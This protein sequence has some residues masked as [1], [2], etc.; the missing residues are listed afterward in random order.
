VVSIQL[1]S[2]LARKLMVHILAYLGVVFVL[3]AGAQMY[4]TFQLSKDNRDSSVRFTIK[5]LSPVL[6]TSLWSYEFTDVNNVADAFINNPFITG[7]TIRDENGQDVAQRGDVAGHM[8]V[9]TR[10]YE[11][12]EINLLKG[13]TTYAYDVW[14]EGRRKVK[15]GEV[16]LMADDSLLFS[17]IQPVFQVVIYSQ[18]LLLLACGLV[19]YLVQNTVVARPLKELA[20]GITGIK[21]GIQ[22]QLP[23]EDLARQDDELGELFRTFNE[24]KTSLADRDRQLLDHQHNLEQKVERR[25]Q[26][27]RLANEELESSLEKLKYAHRDLVESEKLASLGS[28]VTGVAHEVNTPLGVSITATSFLNTELD[29]L[30]RLYQSGEMKKSDLEQFVNDC[31]E[32]CTIL[33]TNLNR[34][35]KLVNSFKQVA[36]DQS[37]EDSRAIA[38]G[39]YIS[40]VLQSLAPRL[41]KSRVTLDFDIQKDVI[42][43]TFP[44]ALA[45][46]ITNLVMNA[47]IH[48]FDQGNREGLIKI[49][50]NYRDE[51]TELVVSDDG[52]GMEAEIKNKIYEPFFTTKRGRGGSGLGL[53][54]VYNLVTQ[55]LH[56]RIQCESAI[57]EGTRFTLTLPGGEVQLNQPAEPLAK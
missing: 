36:V 3:A 28:L 42:L 2:K 1:S 10:G 4:A 37:V 18:L 51:H 29:R 8:Q 50:L 34:A 22:G 47:L 55:K 39:E 5:N 15:V 32:S 40:E 14:Y 30:L 57:G 11:P 6:E 35:A 26:Q 44:G 25:T 19:F 24:M 46:V 48:G 21:Q 53:N 49:E 16:I 9:R 43:D 12:V 27:L 54:I 7:V 23:R 20:E 41:K 31:Q 33:T 45:Q 17:E 13:K 38:V 52:S 56:G